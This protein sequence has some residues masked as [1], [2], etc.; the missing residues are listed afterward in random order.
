VITRQHHTRVPRP[1]RTASG[2]GSPD[3]RPRTRSAHHDL[4]DLGNNRLRVRQ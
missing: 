4:D 1:S 3:D 2:N